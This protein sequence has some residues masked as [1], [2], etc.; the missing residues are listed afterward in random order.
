MAHSPQRLGRRLGR[1]AGL[2]LLEIH[3]WAGAGPDEH[4]QRAFD[5]AIAC[6][7]PRRG[8]GPFLVDVG[9]FADE[10]SGLTLHAQRGERVEADDLQAALGPRGELR[11]ALAALDENDA[12][13]GADIDLSLTTLLA[14]RG[15]RVARARGRISALGWSRELDDAL[16]LVVERHAARRPYAWARA[17][18]YGQYQGEPLLCLVDTARTRAGSLVLPELARMRLFG[19]GAALLPRALALSPLPARA[20][21]GTGRLRAVAI[22]PR[23]KIT[24]ELSAE[25]ES[26]ALFE[27]VD[28]GGEAAYVHR[29][30]TAE[31][32]LLVERGREK[33]V[34]LKTLARYEWGARAG[35]PRVTHRSWGG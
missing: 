16:V 27:V 6:A 9:L 12:A 30:L 34:E 7:S 1:R 22:A 17:V 8:S 25:T 28:P 2:D 24:V 13:P 31:G 11:V 15:L 32:T 3:G 29:A 10:P 21:Y 18:L 19:P 26:T 23:H 35:D 33:I 14:A 20:E 4:G 5:L